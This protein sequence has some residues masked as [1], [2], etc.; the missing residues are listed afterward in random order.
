MNPC[1]HCYQY[2]TTGIREREYTIGYL[3]EKVKNLNE[4]LKKEEILS[5]EQQTIH[6]NRN[7]QFEQQLGLES[8]NFEWALTAEKLQTEGC[9]NQL[10]ELQ[11]ENSNLKNQLEYLKCHLMQEQM[12]TSH[13]QIKLNTLIE[14]M[15]SGEQLE[16]GDDL[17]LIRVEQ[18]EQMESGVGYQM[19]QNQSGAASRLIEVESMKEAIP[20]EM[21]IFFQNQVMFYSE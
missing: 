18:M 17:G 8:I 12:L 4:K 13:L 20:E 5:L 21:Q 2:T 1:Y 3:T 7:Q 15:K 16:T 10:K 11:N 6:Y 19:D 14:Q 9:R